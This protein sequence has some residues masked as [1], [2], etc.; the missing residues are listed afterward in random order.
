L[1]EL[2]Y[3]VAYRNC[4]F[5]LPFVCQHCGR[6][7][8][9][10]VPGCVI[11]G[12][13]AIAEYI[14]VSVEEVLETRFKQIA[15]VVFKDGSKF[16]DKLP[17]WYSSS[18]P[19]LKHDKQCEVYPARPKGCQLFPV[20]TD[21]GAGDTDCPGDVEFKHAHEALFKRMKYAWASA[22]SAQGKRKP[23]PHEWRAILGR[24]AQANP[25]PIMRKHFVAINDV[26]ACLARDFL[27]DAIK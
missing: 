25:S 13:P 9:G 27:R 6:C 2:G 26:P 17:S 16:I 7:C 11:Y 10:P 4:E 20:L 21:F 1:A 22:R 23:R 14:G 19:F 18:C 12:L 5:F 3:F 24:M 8:E 15:R